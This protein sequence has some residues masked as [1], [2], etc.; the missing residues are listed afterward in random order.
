MGIGRE[1]DGGMSRDRGIRASETKLIFHFTKRSLVVST[2]RLSATE[3]SLAPD[4]AARRGKRID[5]PLVGESAVGRE[6]CGEFGVYH[7]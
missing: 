6:R 4:E 5:L 7:L 1:I 2:P 3:L